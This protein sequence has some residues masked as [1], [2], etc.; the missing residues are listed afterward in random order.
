[1]RDMGFLKVSTWK[2]VIRSRKRGKLDPPYI[3]PFRV[4]ARVGTVAYKM[5]LPEELGQIHNTFHVFSYGSP[6]F[7]RRR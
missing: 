1:M 5:D 6:Y 4:I 3:V 2:G 7:M